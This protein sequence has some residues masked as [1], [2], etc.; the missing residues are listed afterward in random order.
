[1]E[2]SRTQPGTAR[3]CQE[4]NMETGNRYVPIEK[5][6]RLERRATV[7][8]LWKKRYE[9]RVMVTLEDMM[10]CLT[11]CCQRSEE[12]QE[13]Y[14]DWSQVEMEEHKYME[15]MRK[16]LGILSLEDDAI[17]MEI[18][19]ELEH[20]YLDRLILELR[21][22]M[23]HDSKDV[24]VLESDNEWGNLLGQDDQETG[25]GVDDMLEVKPIQICIGGYR[26]MGTWFIDNWY[27]SSQISTLNCTPA[28]EV[29]GGEIWL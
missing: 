20:L 17:V 3:D 16:Q 22:N 4:E 12:E 29:G 24:P 5:E 13:D 23:D 27:I 15:G 18:V 11:V 6:D 10:E 7:Q 28:L 14:M 19:P 1:M 9:D 2:S 25:G 8:E 26:K 21:Q